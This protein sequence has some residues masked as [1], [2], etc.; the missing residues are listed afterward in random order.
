MEAFKLGHWQVFPKLNQLILSS[1]NKTETVTPKIMQLLT[2][3]KDH[4]DEP[5]SVEQLI[6]KVWQDRVVADSSVY[7]AIAQLRKVLSQDDEHEVYIER[8][9]GHGYRLSPDIEVSP[10]IEEKSVPKSRW[11]LLCTSLVLVVAIVGIIIHSATKTMQDPHFE[12]LSLAGHLINKTS[13]TQL[14]QAKQLYL[15]VLQQAPNNVEALNG[16]CTSYRLLAIYDTLSDAERDSLCQP[17]L[18]KA[19]AEAPGNPQVLASMAKQA[20][21]QGDIKTSESL[22]DQALAITD[23]DANIWRWYGQLK[24]NQNDVESGLAAHQN[25]FRLAPNDPIV[26]RGLAYAYL[27]N[28]DLTSARKYF[29]RSIIIAPSFKNRALYE[30]DFYPLNQ[31]RAMNY[32]VW[33]NQYQGS[34]LKKFPSHSLS[35]AL[36]LL[37][38]GQVET[39]AEELK[40][41]EALEGITKRFLLYV[42]A[43]LAWAEQ[44]PEEAVAIL[45]QRYLLAPEQNHLVMPYLHA[46][47]HT[48][49]KA[50]ALALFEQHFSDTISLEKLNE[51]Q[52]GRYLLLASMYKSLN[53]EQKYQTAYSKLLSYRQEVR[54]F[55]TEY[56]VIW[57]DL[58]NDKSKTFNHLMKML[59]DGWLPDYNDSMFTVNFYLSLLSNDEE[60]A[61]WLEKLNNIQHC[62]WTYDN[63]LD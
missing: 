7:Q 39:A 15:E 45:K 54:Q 62:L 11:F 41:V 52:L 2:V 34:H 31:Q 27:T 50:Q 18:E 63:C 53:H 49:K 22:L 5:L 48:N 25:A 1:T 12:S 59:A 40:K 43:S 9:S 33:Y 19:Y 21:E 32:L 37:S 3:L 47:F 24:R 6:E 56:E 44:R 23:Q 61:L 28:R 60:K 8:I 36:F 17:L 46:L 57:L 51:E 38:I 14:H 26:L 20:F 30:L 10:L 29:E 35:Y 58:T 4:Q 55:P 13:P 42:K 16:L